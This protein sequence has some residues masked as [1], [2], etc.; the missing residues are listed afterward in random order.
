MSKTI[1]PFEHRPSLQLVAAVPSLRRRPAPPPR[2]PFWIDGP[3]QANEVLY[4]YERS[5]GVWTSDDAMVMLRRRTAQPLSLL[6][7]WIVD[8]LVVSVA[9][10][11]DYLLPVFQFDLANATVR[12]PVFE[13]LEA[14]DG[15]L[16]DLELARW[17]GAPNVLL[18]GA[19]PVDAIE[20]DPR[21]V[22]AAAAERRRND[23]GPP[24]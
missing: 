23:D 14:L 13:V 17:F 1:E 3:A 5:G 7:R 20:L 10:R 12:R 21:A 18:G 8:A 15:T 6:A 9:W 19:A 2:M 11:G 16:K 24:M 22:V 4:A